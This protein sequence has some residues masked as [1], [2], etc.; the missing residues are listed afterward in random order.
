MP[1]LHHVACELMEGR[2]QVRRSVGVRRLGQ[3]VVPDDGPL[4]AGSAVGYLRQLARH[5]VREREL[6]GI[7]L[8]GDRKVEHLI[9]RDRPS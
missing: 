7:K 9:E 5:E 4:G 1:G 2:A 8:C 6:R 3:L